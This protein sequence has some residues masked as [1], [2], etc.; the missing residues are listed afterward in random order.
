[1]GRMW[2]YRKL[3]PSE[4]N[5][6]VVLLL[7]KLMPS[8]DVVNSYVYKYKHK[9]NLVQGLAQFGCSLYKVHN[10][11]LTTNAIYELP[12]TVKLI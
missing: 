8:V 9:R 11:D 2:Q 6:P 5:N 3:T 1:M 7:G 10:I 12:F 4:S